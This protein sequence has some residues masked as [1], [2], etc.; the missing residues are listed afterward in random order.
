MLTVTLSV[1]LSLLSNTNS[2]IIPLRFD[3]AINRLL[4]YQHFSLANLIKD[5]DYN[6][7]PE[8]MLEYMSLSLSNNETSPCER[9]F[10]ITLQ[11]ALNR[12]TWA[13]KVFDAWGKPL[14]SGILKG[15]VYW[16]GNYDECIRPMYDSANKSFISQPFNTQ[17][18]TLVPPA[19]QSN[20][21][22][23]SNS[24]ASLVFGLC[25]PSSCDK[26]SVASLI[27]T[28][29][30]QNNITQ[31][32]LVCSN[33]PPN[34]Q[35]GLT[36][37][38]IVTIVILSLLGLLVLIGTIID[39]ILMSKLNSVGNLTI[40]NDAYNQDEGEM[41]SQPES[42]VTSKY[43]SLN[44]TSRT[45]FLA[46]FSA[47]KSLRRIF[48][49]KEK[50]SGDK[51]DSFL[52]INGI[53]VLSLFWIII[54]HSLLYGLSYTSNVTDILISKRN[55]AFQLVSSAQFSVDTF[56]VLSGFLTAILFVRHVKKE[57]KLSFRLMFL[58]YIHRYIRLT[59]AFLLMVLVSINLTPYFGQ[60]PVYPIEQGFE[61]K[62]CRTRYWWTSILYV[63]NIVRPDDM[64]LN[65]AWY[66]HN[67]M[68]FHWIAPLTLIPFTLGRK[69]LSFII[70]T[71][72]VFVGIGSILS[73]LLYYPNMSLND[74]TG[75]TNNGGGGPTFYKTVY[76]TPWCRISAYA[77]GL[78]TGY[79]I[80]ITGRQDR[81]NRCSKIIGTILVII[82]CLACLFT[83]YPD[84]I[85]VPGLSRPVIVAYVS[86]SRTFWSI[87]IG[88]L[89]FLCSTNQGGIVNEI[90]SWPIWIPLARLNYSCYLVHTMILHII[91][92][93]QTM[94]FYYQGHL[95]INNFIAHIFF[96]Y[97][98]A[99]LVA[100]F[101]ETPFFIVEKK[102]FKR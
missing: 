1:L 5:V 58:Y 27:H 21:N 28:L 35:K 77:V 55:I 32:N 45:V 102:L 66:L 53:R 33:D 97:V 54:A 94:P 24:I 69:T 62:G 22:S 60:G 13:L 48:T 49:I 30:E 83:T 50:S 23:I 56:F 70:A 7:T 75:L 67:D 46:D 100:I 87:V 9:D 72:F 47:L 40:H 64:C 80:I 78:L 63:G 17:H 19:S 16:V 43:F 34:G 92:F 85:H 15:N 81:I 11:A 96:S 39:L 26:Q 88:W 36:N 90:L 89:L 82:I 6:L 12:H 4:Q 95:V 18:C 91:I 86:L 84:S 57:G 31:D 51:N 41:T 73:I 14:P 99:I 61:S 76:V 8:Q 3:L 25:V 10:E 37:G 71:L 93:N 38:A 79:I 20:S 65:I 74:P 52:F 44:L 98:A 101:F 42:R 29:F 68:Q 2:Q 59:P